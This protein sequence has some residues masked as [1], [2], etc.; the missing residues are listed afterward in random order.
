[1]NQNIITRHSLADEVA[2]KLQAKILKGTYK[3]NQK[4]PVEAQL[5]KTY[6]VGRST[7]REAVKILVNSG[8]LRVQQGL[9]TFIDDNTGIN[10]PL[11][12]RLKRSD[13]K[14]I[15]EVRQI[16]EMKVAEKAAA[17]RTG[18]DIS[19]LEYFLGKKTKAV[20]ENLIEECIEAHINFYIVLAEASKNDILTDLYKL[21]AIQLKSDLQA[22][23][24]DTSAFKD[25]LKHHQNLLD[26]VLRQD[27]KK[28]WYFSAKINN[29]LM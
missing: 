10:E 21:L 24:N 8:F 5:M 23:N 3:I 2:S 7:I 19:K 20:E 22:A 14:N 27:S 1:M 26:G 11:F 25:P 17:N 16:L 15:D 13:S 18:N 12:Q 6:G 29:H 4:L 9:G 28:A